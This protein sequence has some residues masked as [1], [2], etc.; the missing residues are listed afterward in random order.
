[1][2]AYLRRCQKRK[3]Y[4]SLLEKPGEKRLLGRYGEWW[5]NIKSFC[6]KQFG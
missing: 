2:F 3:T 1:V 6:K 5:Q 4:K